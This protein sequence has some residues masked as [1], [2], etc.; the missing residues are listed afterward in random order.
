MET[1]LRTFPIEDIQVRSDGEGGHIVDA[2]ASVFDT[3]YE[4]RDWADGHYLEVFRKGAFTKTLSE[5]RAKKF[6]KLK[7]LFNHGTDI[8]G[9][10]S[11][12][13][14]MPIGNP[15][16][17]REDDKGWFTSTHYARTELAEEV[18]EHIREDRIDSQ[19]FAFQPIQSKRTEPA[20]GSKDLP[21]V[22]RIE[23]RVREY[24][25]CIFPANDAAEVVG[26][27]MI[28][29]KLRK[30]TPRQ[31]DELFAEIKGETPPADD[32]PDPARLETPPADDG[33]D[34]GAMERELELLRLART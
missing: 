22:E 14:A 20:K 15:L 10:P 1:I 25:P 2:Y 24:G 12:R 34:L 8:Y 16:E 9:F 33:P 6:R 7:V 13:F 18:L 17:S 3:P 4:V 19:S 31:L 5:H 27:R 29:D 23:V 28:A 11:D 26:V 21:V 30:L 32:G